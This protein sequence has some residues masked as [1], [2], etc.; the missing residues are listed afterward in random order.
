MVDFL[1]IVEYVNKT[2][3]G[4]SN[5]NRELCK[6][7]DE[8]PDL[9]F[10]QLATKADTKLLDSVEMSYQ[11]AAWYL[12]NF[13]MSEASRKCD[14]IPT[15]WP[16]ERHRVR[17]TVAR[18][19]KE[20]LSDD[21]TEVW[22]ENII[23]KYEKRPEDL[24]NVTLAQF[25]AW[26]QKLRKGDWKRRSNPKI[27]RYVNYGASKKDDYRREQCLL[28]IP[29]RNEEIDILDQHQYRTLYE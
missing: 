19:Q 6:L 23:E 16:Q 8:Y 7:R 29:F 3:R 22:C 28:H 5:L 12:L 1:D 14:Y 20:E 4:I 27:I 18:M 11:E 15:T 13:H 2:N 9:D 21:S 26:Y 17:K 24:D 25:A 10:A